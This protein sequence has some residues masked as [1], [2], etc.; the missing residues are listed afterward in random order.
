[1]MYHV[2]AHVRIVEVLVKKTCQNRY[3]TPPF[4][5]STKHSGDHNKKRMCSLLGI[6]P[7]PSSV[8]TTTHPLASTGPPHCM[9]R[10]LRSERR[11]PRH[12]LLHSNHTLHVRHAAGH[13][14]KP[15]TVH[16]AHGGG[17]RGH[18]GA[19]PGVLRCS[20]GGYVHAVLPPEGYAT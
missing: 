19:A 17:C 7:C 8:C 18:G 10:S 3:H 15:S 6:V 5:I 14:A 13:A 4:N 2:C 11:G 16:W 9:G 12:L 1:M 20:A